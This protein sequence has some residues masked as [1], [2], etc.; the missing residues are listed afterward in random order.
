M[1]YVASDSGLSIYS[2][3]S[4]KWSYPPDSIIKG[5]TKANTVILDSRSNL[6]VGTDKGLAILYGG[7]ARF[8][9]QLPIEAAV[10]DLDIDAGGYLYAASS[11]GLFRVGTSAS[12]LSE[13]FPV[14]CVYVDDD[15]GIIY[16]GT[17]KG[18]LS[19]A[20]GGASWTT[21]LVG[22]RILSVGRDESY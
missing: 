12:L 20:N 11:A 2:G 7:A 3:S 21:S 15:S 13:G 14:L 9:S 6:M 5:S 16:A 17:D 4:L 1:S 19:S 8:Q 10:Y 18:L 22:N